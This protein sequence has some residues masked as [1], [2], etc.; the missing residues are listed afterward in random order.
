MH[1]EIVSPEATLF[2]GEVTSIVL[3]GINGEF[4]MLD[5]HANIIS[6]L[7]KGNI[8]IVTPHSFAPNKEFLE[9]FTKADDYRYSLSIQSGTVEMKDNSI[10][11]LAN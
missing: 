11:V 1:L 5:H 3:P 6:I 2:S 4:Q 8:K 7:V 9:K 10:I